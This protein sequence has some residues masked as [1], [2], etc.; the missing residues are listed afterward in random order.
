[1]IKTTVSCYPHDI[2]LS[3]LLKPHER[4]VVHHNPL[5]SDE[6]TQSAN[7]RVDQSEVERCQIQIRICNRHEHRLIDR[8]VAL[9]NLIRRLPRPS[10]IW[11]R[12][13]KRRVCGVD[14]RHPSQ[15]L[16]LAGGSRCH[17]AVVGADSLTDVF[18]LEEDL[19]TGEGQWFGLVA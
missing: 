16:G 10:L 17:V 9:I 14:L 4:L 2:S 13:L 12:N 5:A 7:M 6:D 11:S 8:R 19:A 18:P 1:M 3:V 15:E